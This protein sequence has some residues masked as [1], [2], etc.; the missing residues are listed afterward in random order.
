MNSVNL[1]FDWRDQNGVM[2][3]AQNC[4]L[5]DV[6]E[7]IATA[8][9]LSKRQFDVLAMGHVFVVVQ[10]VSDDCCIHEDSIGGYEGA[11]ILG[12]EDVYSFFERIINE[13]YLYIYDREDESWVETVG[14]CREILNEVYRDVKGVKKSD[15]LESNEA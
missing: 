4:R 2:C 10:F 8:S 3:A 6:N 14:R 5:R 7:F 15:K 9:D 12:C 1:L 11:N 13:E